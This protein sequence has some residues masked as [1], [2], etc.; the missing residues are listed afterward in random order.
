MMEKWD[1]PVREQRQRVELSPEDHVVRHKGRPWHVR[2]ALFTFRLVDGDWQLQ[3]ITL[4][5][6]PNP[7]GRGRGEDGISWFRAP[8]PPW[9]EDLIE[10]ATPRSYS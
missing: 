1:P 4:V 3:H 6:S 10:T 9:L 2:V 7:S 8:C 5:G